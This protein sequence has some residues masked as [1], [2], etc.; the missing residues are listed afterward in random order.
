MSNKF[1][2]KAQAALNNSLLRARE[3]GHTYVGTEHIL[4]GLLTSGDSIAARILNNHGVTE[5]KTFEIIRE[6]LPENWIAYGDRITE[7][8]VD[9]FFSEND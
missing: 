6:N 7:S 4:L 9:D 8:D 1:T 5:E 3:L 2:Q